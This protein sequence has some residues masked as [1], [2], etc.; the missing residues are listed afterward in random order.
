L[1]RAT[2]DLGK[3]SEG[4]GIGGATA[5]NTAAEAQRVT[6]QRPTFGGIARGDEEAEDMSGEREEDDAS[7]I[8]V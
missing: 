8:S 1:R 4:L 6:A 7:F 3:D 5:T 2:G